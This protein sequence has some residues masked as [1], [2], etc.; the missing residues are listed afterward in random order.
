MEPEIKVLLV[1]LTLVTK[2]KLSLL[3]E[4]L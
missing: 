4:K 2:N 3:K 1:S